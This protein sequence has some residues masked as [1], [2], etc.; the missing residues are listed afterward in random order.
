MSRG[1]AEQN[2]CPGSSRSSTQKI[3]QSHTILW[4]VARYVQFPIIA[5]KI[6]ILNPNYPGITPSKNQAEQMY[7]DGQCPAE[8]EC[9][10]SRAEQTCSAETKPVQHCQAEPESPVC[11]AEQNCSAEVRAEHN[12]TATETPSPLEEVRAEQNPTQRMQNIPP[13]VQPDPPPNNHQV[14]AH[15]H[16]AVA[17]VQVQPHHQ[18]CTPTSPRRKISTLKTQPTPHPSRKT[19]PRKYPNKKAK[20]LERIFTNEWKLPTSRSGELLEL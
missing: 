14:Q 7:S 2:D 6:P 18:H 17:Q 12:P 9:P 11:Q 1:Q 19:N 5:S 8:T 4:A 20:H 15:G 10:E 16:A 3:R 13:L